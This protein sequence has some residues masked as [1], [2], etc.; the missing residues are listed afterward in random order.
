VL[1]RRGGLANRIAIERALIARGLLR[2]ETGGR[3]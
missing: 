1:E 3:R 2:I